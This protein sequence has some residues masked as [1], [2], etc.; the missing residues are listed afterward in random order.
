M[1]KTRQRREAAYRQGYHDGSQGR[2][3]QR[4]HKTPRFYKRGYQR[5]LR[6]IR[7]SQPNHLSFT[8]EYLD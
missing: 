5:A 3:F 4:G 7:L 8:D 2:P 1:S 6:D